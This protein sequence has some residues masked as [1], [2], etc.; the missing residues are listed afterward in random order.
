MT[1]LMQFPQSATGR[2]RLGF[3]M[4]KVRDIIL[5][6]TYAS[7]LILLWDGLITQGLV[8]GIV[9]AAL[10]IT[11]VRLRPNETEFF[12]SIIRPLAAIAAVP[13]LWMVIQLLPLRPLAHPVWAS[14]EVALG[15][16]LAGAISVDLGASLIALG[17]YLSFAAVALVSAAIAVDRQRAEWLLFAV[18]AATTLV[19][20]IVI[21]YDLFSGLRYLRFSIAQGIDC[22]AVGTIIAGAAI[23]RTIERREIRHSSAS[24]L[25]LLLSTTTSSTALAISSLALLVN[26]ARAVFFAVACGLAIL[27]CARMIRGFGRAA[28]GFLLIAVLVTIAA[29]LL[30]AI[31]PVERG[32]NLL[33]AFA[34]SPSASSTALAVRML[35]DAPPVGTG[36]GT[37]SALAPIYREM[38]DPPTDPVAATAAAVVSIELGASVFWLIVTATVGSIFFLVITSLQRGRDS[39]Y[40][41]MGAGCLATLLLLAFTNLGVLGTPTSLIAAVTLGLAFAQSKSRSLHE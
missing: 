2:G 33:L 20:L 22:A 40:S 21:G 25:D 29:L 27:V 30:V 18:I 8:A 36:A 35:S 15:H 32:A 4:S 6:L 13:A 16:P 38:D 12:I 7:P 9:A 17:K 31:T 1:G 41:A 37:F 23:I 11:A 14:A 26:G 28:W 19:A 10:M 3:D 5:A 34:T 24:A 39:F